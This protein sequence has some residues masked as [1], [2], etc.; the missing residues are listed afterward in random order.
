[1]HHPI[2]G[3]CCISNLLKMAYSFS[4]GIDSIPKTHSEAIKESGW[5]YAMDYEISKLLH[6]DIQELTDLP[7][8]RSI[9]R[10]RWI[11]TIKH[12]R[13]RSIGCL[14]ARLVA[15]GHTN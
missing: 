2:I 1:M 3:V 15:K 7:L 5:Y 6:N 10:C 11:Y 9:G 8:G 13:D 12:N 14:N 4:F